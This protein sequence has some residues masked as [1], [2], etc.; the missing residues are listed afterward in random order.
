MWLKGE[1]KAEKV[2]HKG[3]GNKRSGVSEIKE[4]P[5]LNLIMSL[6]FGTGPFIKFD[7]LTQF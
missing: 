4:K 2:E 5:C 3:G 1:E 7:T 6:F